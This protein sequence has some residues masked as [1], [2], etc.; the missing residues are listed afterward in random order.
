MLGAN[1]G[2]LQKSGEDQRRGD[3]AGQRAGGALGRNRAVGI[4]ERRQFGGEKQFARRFEEAL[5][6]GQIRHV[7]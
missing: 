2:A 1:L 4:G 6:H 7:V 3:R 5:Q